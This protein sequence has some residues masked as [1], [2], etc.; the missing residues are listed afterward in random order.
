MAPAKPWDSLCFWTQLSMTLLTVNVQS[1]VGLSQLGWSNKK[2]FSNPY[3][4]LMVD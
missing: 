4:L 2:I 3:L 1:T